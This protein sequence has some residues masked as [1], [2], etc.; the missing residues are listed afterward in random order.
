MML[1]R[2]LLAIFRSL[3]QFVQDNYWHRRR[4]WPSARSEAMWAAS[5]LAVSFADLRRPWDCTVFASDASLSGIGVCKSDFS[6]KEVEQIGIFKEAWRYKTRSPIAPRK[7]TISHDDISEG[8]DPFLDIETVKP[9]SLIREDPFEL[10]D[11]F[12][13]IDGQLMDPKNWEFVFAAQMKFPEA[14]TVL[15]FRAILASLRHKLR[16]KSSF[17]KKHL[18]FSDNLSAVLC[19]GKGRSSSFPML[20]A[21]RRLCALLIAANCQL[22]VRWIPSEWNV[23]DHGSRLWEHQR[24]VAERE[25]RKSKK[26]FK[27]NIDRLCYPNFPTWTSRTILPRLTSQP[28][29]LKKV[30][31]QLEG[32]TQEERFKKRKRFLENV[33][34]TPRFPGQTFL[35]QMAV[36]QEVATDYLK[37]MKA[38]KAFANKMHLKLRPINKLDESFSIYLNHLF[39]EGIDVSEG[40]KTLAALVDARPDASQKGDLPRSR[41]SLQGWAKLDPARTRPP[42]PY[43]L[44][45]LLSC[46]MFEKNQ[47]EAAL[48]VLLSFTAYLRPSEALTLRGEDIVGPTRSHPHLALN[49]HPE[50]RLETSKM[51]LSNESI[52]LD[53][54]VM[55]FLNFGLKKLAQHRLGRFLFNLDYCQLRNIWEASMKDIGLPKNHSVLYQL[56]HSGPSHDRLHNLRS[57]LA[58]KMRGRWQ[59]D[60]SVKRYEAHARLHQQFQQ[61]PS[62][63]QE[64]CLSAVTRLERLV[65]RFSPRPNKSL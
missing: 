65:L 42:M 63:L 45:A 4:L 54:P 43:P 17:G 3:Y 9:C 46:N 37:R 8:L 59:S 62:Q 44:V 61:L 40:F 2:E 31:L 10:N 25:A 33:E 22:L 30:R 58:V 1:R 13:E 15:E 20:R 56:R 55:P 14:I 36:T 52:L 11:A 64:K 50:E 6:H 19:A 35:E 5:L 34:M 47:G 60:S 26:D 48:L 16:V 28:A 39:A 29:S 32:K 38:F 12:P 27:K 49:L 7:A 53:S 21:S 23:A 57:A 51:G 18:H 24:I 41:R